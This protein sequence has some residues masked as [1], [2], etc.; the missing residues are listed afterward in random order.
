[1]LFQQ[2][3][4]PVEQVVVIEQRTLAFVRLVAHRKLDDFL[5]MVVQMGKINLDFLLERAALVARHTNRL[6][7][8]TLLREAAVARP[9][10]HPRPQQ[11]Y[12][13]LHV[14]AVENREVGLKSERGAVPAEHSVGE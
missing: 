2:L 7:N 11:V 4:H 12:H 3:D 1:M 5:R 10:S 14:G 8:R 13:V 6:G 9:Q